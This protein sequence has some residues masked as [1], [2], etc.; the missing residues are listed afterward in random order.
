L[1]AKYEQRCNEALRVD[2]IPTQALALEL[3]APE[4]RPQIEETEDHLRV[5]RV[6]P[7]PDQGYTR[8]QVL[9]LLDAGRA[10]LAQVRAQ[11]EKL[12]EAKR[13]FVGHQDLWTAWLMDMADASAKFSQAQYLSPYDDPLP[14]APKGIP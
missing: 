1:L 9:T 2:N 8:A 4:T 3:A 5:F 7:W 13:T 6:L 12:G 10:D 14:P 11:R